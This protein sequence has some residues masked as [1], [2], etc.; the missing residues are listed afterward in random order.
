[1]FFLSL[2]SELITSEVGSSLAALANTAVTNDRQL[3]IQ[4]G[5]RGH[6]KWQKEA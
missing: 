2:F 4:A 1:M 6:Y 3:K 5:L